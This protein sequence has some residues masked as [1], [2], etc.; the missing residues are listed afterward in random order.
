M[1]EQPYLAIVWQSA[2]GSRRYAKRNGY[3]PNGTFAAEWVADASR[4]E[5]FTR[6]EARSIRGRVELRS[7][8]KLL[9]VDGPLNGGRARV[10]L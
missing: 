5:R 2:D 10:K 1:N 7:G 3:F 9:F 6:A 4:A 8:D